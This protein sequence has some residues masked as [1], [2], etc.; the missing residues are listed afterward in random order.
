MTACTSQPK[1]DKIAIPAIWLS[2]S[3]LPTEGCR[4][5]KQPFR[6]IAEWLVSDF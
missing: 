3:C 5:L 6:P 1:T 4:C 2:E